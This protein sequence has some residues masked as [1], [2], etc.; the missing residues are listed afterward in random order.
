MKKQV[1]VNG[2][3]IYVETHGPLRGS[4]VI[5]LHHGIGAARSWKEQTPILAKA[6]YRTLV[7]DRWGHGK[8]EARP[9]LGVPY[10]EEDLDDLDF[11]LNWF[12]LQQVV[13]IGHS[14]GGK[15]AM[16]YAARC[17][18]RLFS[19]IVVS[20]HIYVEP[21]MSPGIQGV[22]H[23]FENDYRFREKLRRVHGDKAETLF[24][25]W[26]EGWTDPRNLSWDMRPILSHISCPTLVI[27]GIQDEHA[28]PQHA[29][30]IAAAIP[31]AE[32]WL[33]PEATHMV[34]QDFPMIF[35]SK[36]LEFLAL[37]VPVIKND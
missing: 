36:M 17:P 8:S 6:G 10:F 27:Q 9:R 30:D 33:V 37:T 21:K 4:P 1:L 12:R 28:T 11:L 16:Y 2:H 35:N 25:L 20:T 31:C 22:L 13:L 15:I 18:Q 3:Q 32:L 23:N 19:L 34:P 29:R 7:Y 5:L 26:Y 14:D 24:H